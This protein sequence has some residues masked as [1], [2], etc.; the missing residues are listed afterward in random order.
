MEA[1]WG[2]ALLQLLK[3]PDHLNCSEIAE[4]QRNEPESTVDTRSSNQW[5]WN[6]LDA[7]TQA[8]SRRFDAS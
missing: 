3:L 4:R 6:S 5:C 2:F 8:Y 1:F 7:E